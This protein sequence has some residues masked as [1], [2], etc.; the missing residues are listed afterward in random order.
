MFLFS[1]VVKQ[2]AVIPRVKRLTE[3]VHFYFYC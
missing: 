1:K 2:A 3:I